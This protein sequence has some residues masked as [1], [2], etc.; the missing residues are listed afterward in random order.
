MRVLTLGLCSLLSLV[1]LAVATPAAAPPSG[2]VDPALAAKAQAILKKSC[3]RCHGQEGS[4]EGG[5]NF[6]LDRDMLVARRKLLPH[7]ADKSPLFR[8]ILKGSM[9]PAGES[10][11][12][13]REE[14]ALLRR[15]IDAG[16]PALRPRS[17][18]TLVSESAVLEWILADLDRMDRR[19]RR[20]ARYFSLVPLAN[21]GHGPDEL[22]TYRNA[23]AKLI[24]SL[25]W[26]PRIAVPV[27]IGPDGLV[28]RID[29][30]DYQLDANLWN[31]LLAEYPYG[32]LH[33]TGVARAVL[34]ATATR[35][36]VVRADWFV[37]T[38][39][40]AP[41]YYDL[42]QIPTNLNELERQLRVDVAVNI[43]QERVARA[44]F[45]G[46]GISR[47][48]RILERHDAMNGAYWRTYDFEAVP[49][50]LIERNLLLP[51]R[52]NVFAYPL[53]PNLGENGFQHAGGEVIFNLP[54]GLHAF[55]LVN[56]ANQRINKGPTEIVSDPKRPDRAVEAGLSC[57]N[58][59]ARGIL[60]KDD[61]LREHVRKNRKAFSRS[62]A[63]L[64]E[65]L[66]PPAKKMRTLME[67]DARRF[68]RAV[69]K[70]GN[71]VTAAEVVM[72]MTLR[73]EADVDLATLAA[74]LG[75]AAGV[76]RPK[77]TATEALARNLGALEVPGGVVA[78]QVV[79]QAFPDLVRELK[80]GTAIEPGRTGES[81]PDATGEADPLE[82]QSSP[83]NA[84]AFSPDGKLAAFASAD[85]SVRIHD[86]DSR[87][88]LRRCIGHTASVWCVAFSPDGARILSGG[89]DG[90]VRLWD[91][92]TA[93]ELKKIE[94]HR[95]LVSAVAFTP[96][97][98][99]ALSA[100]YDH[101]LALWDLERGER[102]SGF[103][104]ARPA[105]YVHAL[106]VSVDGKYALAGGE[107]NLYLLETATGK[108]VRK[109]MG[110]TGWING[111]AFA[112]DGKHAV[113]AS[114]DG[115]A[116]MW[117]IET[118][119]LVQT[120]KGHQGAVKAAVMDAGE[121]RVLTGGADATVRLWQ[122]DGKELRVFRKHAE[123]VV[124]VA[125]APDGTSTLSGSRDAV[126]HPWS[127]GAAAI[128]KPPTGASVPRIGE[129]DDLLPLKPEAALSVGGTVGQLLLSPDRKALYYLNLT[130]AVVGKVQ[131][132][133]L[134]RD[135]VL[136]LR[137][138]TGTLALSADGKLLVAPWAD[139]AGKA[140]GELQL[141]DTGSLALRPGIRLDWRP[142]DV[143]V[144]D[145]VVYASQAGPEWSALVAV[146]LRKGETNR[147]VGTVWAKSLVRLSPDG[148]RL[149]VSS[150]G[151]LPGTLDAFVV[152]SKAGER[153]V[154][155]RAPGHDKLALGGEFVLAPDGHY[156]ICKTGT[157]LRL[158]GERDEDLKLHAR[159]GPLLAAAVDAE[160]KRAWVVA[161]DGT[162]KKYSYPEFRLQ[163]RYRPALA[164]YRVAVDGKAGR[165]YVAGFDP[166][167][168]GERPR[169]PGHG[170]IHVYA[171]KE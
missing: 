81:L 16:A 20:F 67:A 108:L 167:S 119:K 59:H 135:G 34:V 8:R 56:A 96:D 11:R 131:A 77:L 134:R 42:L 163:G 26:H 148:K 18:R 118:S 86:L 165:L 57:M 152:G 30:R 145:G 38:A 114:D 48:N 37:A 100:G 136:S 159:L 73:Y 116:R 70:T 164:A 36:P 43:Q 80:L 31:R 112:A 161:V 46:S 144:G 122:V 69:E 3:H 89:K 82:V 13:S 170:D 2:T 124:A 142:H 139:P 168:V 143:A 51:D 92:E 1:L 149:Y 117:E 47:N 120:F 78:R 61:Q 68:Q 25:S 111:L 97:G 90:T 19:A 9:P 27:A 60:V 140:A 76:L 29:L 133:S 147:D 44:G 113:S 62:D 72:A 53:G 15:W 28:L 155:Y 171:V 58:C 79:V 14:I 17:A 102:V 128:V 22:N 4:V 123:P 32:I 33:D 35:M 66:Y 103:S 41:L 115:T 54:N 126:V 5:L 127:I 40:R 45:N 153:S 107:N 63:E 125:F 160:G 150:Q 106:A 132:G 151:V 98:K 21:A 71:K 94:A 110:H 24:N 138:G 154:S 130:N 55:V 101:E 65:A 166:R 64:V 137:A 157:V 91:V 95:D 104:F 10:P 146:P 83:A 12:P 49:Q 39:S 121:K 75:L 158:S 129:K 99:R 141:I 162:L 52:R 156:L 93:R 109:L 50:N 7:Q 88:D 84:L 74:E 105:R 169:A 6:I 85:R 23:L 87:R